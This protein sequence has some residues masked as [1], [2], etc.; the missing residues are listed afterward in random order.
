MHE[1]AGLGTCCTSECKALWSE[2]EEAPSFAIVVHTHTLHGIQTVQ[3]LVDRIHT[4]QMQWTEHLVCHND[5]V[6][7]AHTHNTH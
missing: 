6:L 2:T 4:D 1:L 5:S 7:C 3:E